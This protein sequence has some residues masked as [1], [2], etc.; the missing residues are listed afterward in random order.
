MRM[1]FIITSPGS[2]KHDWA[3]QSFRAESRFV[4]RRQVRFLRPGY[5]HQ[6][7]SHQQQKHPQG[8]AGEGVA[9]QGFGE[10]QG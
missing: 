10:D 7:R 2:I 1:A 9:Q 8:T 3:A 6:T 4:S 5:D